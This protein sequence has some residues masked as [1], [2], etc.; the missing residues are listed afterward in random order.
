M[1]D[2]M[3]FV[4][5]MG[6]AVSAM[7][8]FSWGEPEPDD[9]AAVSDCIFT[10]KLR[11]NDVLATEE[12]GLVSLTDMAALYILTGEGAAVGYIEGVLDSLMRKPGSYSMDVAYRGT[13]VSIG[14]GSGDPASSSHK[15]YV[16][17]YG[18]A[19]EVDLRLY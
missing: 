10:A 19:V 12:S 4:V 5:V 8:A 17:T 9:A 3:I 15:E 2:A 11:M 1:V 7:F 14:S 13:T 6:L 18:G 16:V